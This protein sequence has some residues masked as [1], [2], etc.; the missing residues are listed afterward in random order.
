MENFFWETP[1]KVYFGEG[2]V[3]HLP[4]VRK[5]YGKRILLTYGKNSIKKRGLY[6][7]VYALLKGFEIYEL[8]GIEPNPKYNPSVIDGVKIC[9]EKK[10]DVILSVGGGSVLD[11]SK[12]IAGSAFYDGDPW[13]II[14]GKAKTEKALPIVDILTLSATGSE[15][16]D[17]GVISRKE[18]ND[19]L[20]YSSPLVYPAYSFLDPTYTF[21]VSKKQTAAGVADARNHVFEQYFATP[22]TILNDGFREARL[23]SLMTNVKIA[24]QDPENLE[25]RSQI[26]WDCSF[27]CN[28]ILSCGSGRSGWPRHAREHAL[29]AYYDITHGIGLAILTPRWRE[30]I[31]NRKSVDRFVSYGKNVLGLKYD[32]GR[33]KFVFARMAIK[34]TYAFF[35]SLGIPRHLK[36]VGI[37]SSRLEE[38]TEH[39]VENEGLDKAW[40]PLF[41][42]DILAILKASL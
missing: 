31:L 36:D 3:K 4:S 2:V 25:A 15:F 39:I 37:D 23:R 33:D 5:Q 32:E 42:D 35:E 22:S 17:G 19:K 9:K 10:I 7:K 24:L 13:D 20:C 14:I 16:D 8:S 26:R 28:G 12:A 30:H 18:T 34:E 11:C 27:G 41:H 6:D 1:T 21:S 40:E 29:S 38:R